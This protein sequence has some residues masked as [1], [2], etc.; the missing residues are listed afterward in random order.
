MKKILVRDGRFGRCSLPQPRHWPRT[1]R[2]PSGPRV[3]ALVG[4]DRVKAVGEKDGGV[5]FGIG[6]GY[7]FAVGNGVSLGADVEATEFDPEGRRCGHRPGEGWPR[8]LRRRPRHLR[9]LA[10]GQPLREGRLH[11]CPLQGDRR[12]RHVR[13]ELRRLPSRRRRPAAPSAARPMS[14]ANI[15]TPTMKHGLARHQLALTVGT[16]F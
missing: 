7:D 13:D 8:P 5:L 2:P 3:E 1:L 12:C 16:R 15:A 9:G 6:A 10:D 14:A 4:Y 11:Q